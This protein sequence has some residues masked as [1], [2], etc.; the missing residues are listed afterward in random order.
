MII[1]TCSRE[2]IQHSQYMHVYGLKVI[3]LLIKKTV[4]CFFRLQKSQSV[5]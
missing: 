5:P 4:M 3:V 2:S 1:Y